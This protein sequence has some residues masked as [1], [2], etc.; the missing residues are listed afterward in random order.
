MLLIGEVVP[1][2]GPPPE[3]FKISLSHVTSARCWRQGAAVERQVRSTRH[4][5]DRR[6]YPICASSSSSPRLLSPLTHYDG[7]SSSYLSVIALRMRQYDLITLSTHDDEVLRKSARAEAE[8]FRTVVV[9]RRRWP[10][11]LAP[12]MHDRR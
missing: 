9:Y 1:R 8:G 10:Q 4:A 3:L 11:Q 7:N 5:S 6:V 12:S 2:C